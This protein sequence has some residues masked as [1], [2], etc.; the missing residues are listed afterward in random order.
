MSREHQALANELSFLAKGFGCGAWSGEVSDAQRQS[1]SASMNCR[2]GI[3]HDTP[4]CAHIA[5]G[6][7]YVHVS[8]QTM[9]VGI[10]GRSKGAFRSG[11]QLCCGLLFANGGLEIR[12][13][14]PHFA[15]DRIS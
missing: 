12:P 3:N 14:L 2:A 13:C 4:R 7:R 8:P 6:T 11:N 9:L 10:E 1:R 5:L 15:N